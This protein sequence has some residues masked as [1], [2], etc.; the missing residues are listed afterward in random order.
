MP[1]DEV[2]K[3]PSGIIPE[4][5]ALNLNVRLGFDYLRRTENSCAF[6]LRD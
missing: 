5:A 1:P 6:A 3:Q 2:Y 4:I